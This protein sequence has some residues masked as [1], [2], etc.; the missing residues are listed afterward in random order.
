VLVDAL[1]A[2]SLDGC[3]GDRG[4][5][6]QVSAV[7]QPSVAAGVDQRRRACD[8][9]RHPGPER[10]SGRAARRR[11]L[12][13]GAA[14]VRRPA[15]I[16]PGR[17]LHRGLA[18]SRRTPSVALPVRQADALHHQRDRHGEDDRWATA[19][20]D[21]CQPRTRGRCAGR[22]STTQS[23][24]RLSGSRVLHHEYTETSARPIGRRGAYRMTADPVGAG[25]S[26][27]RPITELSGQISS[28]CNSLTLFGASTT[29]TRRCPDQPRPP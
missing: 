7:G 8:D 10:P 17:R 23:H 2:G 3:A 27:R 1:T 4:L 24:H 16:V 22:Q 26:R 25:R 5:S 15:Q 21:R 29:D 20:R 12:R 6:A 18:A 9:A 28:R 14:P 11:R 19:P 13:I